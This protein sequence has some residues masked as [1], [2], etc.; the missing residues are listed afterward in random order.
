MLVTL[1][2]LGIV[3]NSILCPG[4]G[5]VCEVLD[6]ALI[7]CP[8]IRTGWARFLKLLGSGAKRFAKPFKR[9]GRI[10]MWVIWKRRNR[11]TFSTLDQHDSIIR[12]DSFKDVQMLS[13][14]WVSNRCRGGLTLIIGYA[15][16]CTML[17][18]LSVNFFLFL[19]LNQ[20]T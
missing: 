8:M 10:A 5:D 13:L 18:F 1:N 11:I 15:L 4:C 19:L 14:L 16:A 17:H 6:H 3:L 12:K 9:S 20:I 7:N 2:N